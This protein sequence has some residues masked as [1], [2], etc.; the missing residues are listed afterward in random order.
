MTTAEVARVAVLGGGAWGTALAALAVEAG[1]ATTLWVR[2]PEAAAEIASTRV[3]HRY[4]PGRLLDPGLVVTADLPEAMRGAALVVVALPSTSL[5]EICAHAKAALAP[6][7]LIVCASKGFEEGTGRTLDQLLG[8]LLPGHAIALLSGPTFA[9]EIA[10]GLPAAA[11]VAS[12]DAAAAST[13]QRALGGELFRIYTSDDVVGVAVGGALKNVIAIAAGCADGLGFGSNGR[14]ALITRGLHE[15]GRLAA[16][17]GGDPLTLAGLAGLGDL[18]LTCT[19]EL[20]RNR[21]V[22]LALARGEPVAS[23]VAH[24][25][26]VAEGVETARTAVAMAQR[27]GVDMPITEKVAAVLTGQATAREAVAQLLSRES[28]SERG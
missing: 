11:V 27:L 8:D 15:M 9:V 22:G 24:L 1:H 21:R 13:V 12:R 6:G 10:R 20:S 14:A 3:N 23:I 7:A 28:G 16:R 5:H 19:G 26:Q 2:R 25:G 17:L 4:L 18:V